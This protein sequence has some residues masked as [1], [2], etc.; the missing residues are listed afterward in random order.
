MKKILILALI[1]LS[2]VPV[3][4]DYRVDDL[5][6]PSGL[7]TQWIVIN[8]AGDTFGA[9]N[10]IPI[11]ISGDILSSGTDAILNVING[12]S[13]N[14]VNDRNLQTLLLILSEGQGEFDMGMRSQTLASDVSTPN[15]GLNTIVNE[16]QTPYIGTKEPDQSSSPSA[17]WRNFHFNIARQ[18]DRNKYDTVIQSLIFQQNPANS[19]SQ[20]ITR[21]IVI[22]NVHSNTAASTSAP[23]IVRMTLRD[24]PSTTGN[25]IAYDRA[26]W[27]MTDNMTTGGNQWVFIPVD[28]L[29]TDNK[30]IEYHLTTEIANNTSYRYAARYADSTGGTLPPSSWKFDIM[31]PQGTTNIP[32]TF[33]LATESQIAPG[34]VTVF[35]RRYNVNE[36]NKTPIHVFPVDTPDYGDYDLTLNHK[37]IFGKDLGSYQ[38]PASEGRFNLFEINAFEPRLASTTFYNDVAQITNSAGT[39]AVPANSIFSS[40]SVQREVIAD[41]VLEY[42]TVSQNIPSS[43]RSSGS[44]GLLPLHITMNIPVTRIADN[45]WWNNMLEVWRNTGRVEDMFANKFDLYLRAGDDNVWNLTQELS[46][47]GVYN[48]LVKV[49]VDENRGRLTQDNYSGVLTVSFIAML[50]DGTRDGV[51]PELSIVRDNSVSQENRY[52]VI[53]DGVFDNKWEMTFFIAPSGWQDN[54]NHPQDNSTN[55]NQNENGQSGTTS[56]GSGGSGGCASG[57]G[58]TALVLWSLMSV[59]RER[60]ERRD[61]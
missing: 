7:S 43:V 61:S 5:L 54:P 38:Y 35:E 22:S 49:F 1:A 31:R 17:E 19:S 6:G 60:R 45:V 40:S 4:A 10:Q 16:N 55:N 13:D 15:L 57:F 11:R 41:D 8:E 34:L 47:K 39:V 29:N 32:R 9:S 27:T 26:V 18:N 23:L 59:R 37:I 42:F 48:D 58:L 20:T 25:I 44:E 50:M 52:I 33:L 28:D 14:T 2:A 51:R 53:R 56:G 3:F 30:R 12:S 24:S 46:D 21:P 36:Q